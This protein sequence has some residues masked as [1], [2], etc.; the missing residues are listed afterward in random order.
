M[1]LQVYVSYKTENKYA[2][3]YRYVTELSV[4]TR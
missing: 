3:S 4:K 1:L 2:E